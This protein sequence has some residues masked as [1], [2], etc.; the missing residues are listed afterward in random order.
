MLVLNPSIYYYTLVLAPPLSLATTYGITIVFFSCRYLDVSV[1][2][3]S[4]HYTYHAMI[5]AFL[6][7][8]SSLIRISTDLWL[9]APPR[10]FSQLVTSFIGSWYQGILPMLLLAWPYLSRSFFI[11][12]PLLSSSPIFD[13]PKSHLYLNY[14]FHTISCMLTLDTCYLFLFISIFVVIIH[15]IV[16]NVQFSYM[17]F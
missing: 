17:R 13:H 2:Y 6:S 1:P 9:F 8:V 16:F 11:L 3:V 7:Q 15:Y 5:P 4:P 10:S 12:D 14:S